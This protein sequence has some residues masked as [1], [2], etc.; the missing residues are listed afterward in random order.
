MP[1]LQTRSYHA[2]NFVR[3]FRRWFVPYVQSRVTASEF[4]PLLSYLFT[5]WK[6]NVDCHY[7]WAFNNKVKGM[8]EETAIRSIDWLKSV[9]CRV[10]A[11]M[12]GEPLLRRD[13]ILD[14]SR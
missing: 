4:R 3:A 10:I 6:C 2:N 1:E 9:G 12:G 7:C 13:F 14:A 11:I 8:T 5:E